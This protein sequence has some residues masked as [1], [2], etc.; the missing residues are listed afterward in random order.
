MCIINKAMTLDAR[1]ILVIQKILDLQDD[2]IID[3]LELLLSTNT[4]EIL[5]NP[6]MD[7]LNSDIEQALYDSKIN[8]V[9]EAAELKAKYKKR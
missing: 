4:T 7:I 1:K 9:T 8:R 2:K 6:E 5:V 3:A